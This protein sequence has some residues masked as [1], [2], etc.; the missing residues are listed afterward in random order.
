MAI[1]LHGWRLWIALFV[2][3]SLMRTCGPTTG[4]H[5]STPPL[6]VCQAQGRLQPH[7]QPSGAVCSPRPLRPRC[8][9]GN[10]DHLGTTVRY[11]LEGG[12]HKD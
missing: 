4:L 1:D 12:C 10:W 3:P 2:S 5:P 7:E 9:Y 6:P 11:E 8:T